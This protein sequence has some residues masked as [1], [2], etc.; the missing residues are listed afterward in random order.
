MQVVRTNS[1]M[2]NEHVQ[3][4][5]KGLIDRPKPATCVQITYV[6]R[7]GQLMKGAKS[8]QESR[9]DAQRASQGG[10]EQSKGRVGGV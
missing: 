10:R 3:E 1:T 8:R 9:A 4:A 2:S 5:T 7:H 6:N